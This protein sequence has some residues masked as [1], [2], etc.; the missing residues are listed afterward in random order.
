[1]WTKNNDTTFPLGMN[2]DPH[3]EDMEIDKNDKSKP[4]GRLLDIPCKVC[5]D[6]SSGK[7]Y[8]I[9]ACDGCSGFFKRS[10]RR[11]RSYTCRATNGKGN[12]PVDKI[13][14]NQ[15][16][17]CR[18]KK[19]FEVTMNKDAVQHERGPRSSTLRKQKMLKEAQDRMDGATTTAHVQH[20]TSG[21]INTLLAAETC[22]EGCQVPAND[23]D[24]GLEFKPI[25]F[26]SDFSVSMYYSNPEAVCEAAA[27]LLF[28]SVKWARNIP[29]FMSLPFRDQVIL[30]EEGWRELFLLGASQWS[31]PL[32]IAP[33]LSAAGMHVD[34]TPP[35]T[36]VDV[37]ATVRLIQETVNK[38][39]A[40]NVDSTEYACLKAIV[41]F[42]PTAC[43]LKDPEQVESTQDQA[44]LMLGEYVRA[45][46]P[47]QLARFGRLLLL[48]PT[49]RRI[50]AKEIEELFFKKTI[51]TVP[52]ERLLSD[53]FKNE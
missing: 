14:R 11:N 34:N 45:Q 53:M 27:K 40:A 26:Q 50:S 32:E 15:C 7:H 49:L 17:S 42:K 37:M 8:G 43:G 2:T 5:G 25:R 29:S 3:L 10:I 23:F 1:M 21:F 33:I 44:Q 38:F 19:C 4:N 30:L 41:L 35:E 9:Y 39:K 52:I 16:R 36:I 6:R 13:H 20:N 46:C 24:L 47:T 28:M 48:L 18:L 12:C 31:M 51:G 22:M